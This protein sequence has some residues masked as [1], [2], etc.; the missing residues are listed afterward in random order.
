M[1]VELF[2]PAHGR[3]YCPHGGTPRSAARGALMVRVDDE[4]EGT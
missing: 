2:V 1:T 3:P 4:D